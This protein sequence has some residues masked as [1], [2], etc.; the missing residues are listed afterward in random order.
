MKLNTFLNVIFLMMILNSKKKTSL[1]Y[2]SCHN[3]ILH[4]KQAQALKD[5]FGEKIKSNTGSSPY[6]GAK[7]CNIEYVDKY[8]LIEELI[9]EFYNQL[10][11]KAAFRAEVIKLRNCW[12]GNMLSDSSKGTKL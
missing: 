12:N 10:E 4:L 1:K 11:D 8:K 6:G 9:D 3:R 7:C 5:H 2:Q